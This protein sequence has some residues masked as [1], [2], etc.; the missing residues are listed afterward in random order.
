M[1]DVLGNSGRTRARQAAA[2]EK[3]RPPT[4]ESKSTPSTTSALT[5][6]GAAE[7]ANLSAFRAHSSAGERSLHTREVPGSIPGAPTFT[8][9]L[10]ERFH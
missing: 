6:A 4:G 10:V 5:S 1:G 3:R 2:G 7:T 9:G 8:I